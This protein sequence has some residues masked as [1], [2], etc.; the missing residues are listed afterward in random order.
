MSEKTLKQLCLCI[1]TSNINI[2]KKQSYNVIICFILMNKL[3][4]QVSLQDR[5]SHFLCT[6]CWQL[7]QNFM[8]FRSKCISSEAFLSNA[9]LQVSRFPSTI[10]CTLINEQPLHRHFILMPFILML[11]KINIVTSLN[12]I[13]HVFVFQPQ[14][15]NEKN[16]IGVM[17]VHVLYK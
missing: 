4:I 16:I 15:Q 12:V 7:V 1:L 8:D 11:E 17:F 5:L 2:I 3:P 14:Y 13:Y 9:I 6:N 10:I